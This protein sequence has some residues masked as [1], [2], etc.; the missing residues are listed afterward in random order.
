[1]QNRF[2]VKLKNMAKKIKDRTETWL[3]QQMWVCR[4]EINLY[5]T[6][7]YKEN[8]TRYAATQYMQ[9]CKAGYSEQLRLHREFLAFRPANCPPQQK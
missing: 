7:A 1:M 3:I 2:S 9:Q 6:E 4:R 8:P 5:K